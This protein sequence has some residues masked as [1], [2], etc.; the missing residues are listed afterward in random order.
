MI[1]IAL[2]K[3]IYQYLFSS[4]Q[5]NII[6]FFCC[7]NRNLWGKLKGYAW[8]NLNCQTKFKTILYFSNICHNTNINPYNFTPSFKDMWH[9]YRSAFL[10]LARCSLNTGQLNCSWTQNTWLLTYRVA[11]ITHFIFLAIN[12]RNP[13][14]RCRCRKQRSIGIISWLNGVR[15]TSKP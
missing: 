1:P 12:F 9:W 13:L 10:C 6:I 15:T 5:Y 11:C 4:A 3:I 8:Q 2:W 7:E 14:S